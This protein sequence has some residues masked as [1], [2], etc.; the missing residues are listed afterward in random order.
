[1]SPRTSWTVVTEFEVASVVSKAST[2]LTFVT[3]CT[4]VTSFETSVVLELLGD[5]VSCTSATCSVI[6][7]TGAEVDSWTVSEVD[8]WTVADVDYSGGFWT[9]SVLFK[10][11]KPKALNT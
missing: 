7:S 10:Y 5:S 2:S 9:I 1:M 4:S 11:S 8:S 6:S 3:N